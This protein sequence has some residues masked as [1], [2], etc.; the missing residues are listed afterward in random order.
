MDVLTLT[1]LVALHLGVP[2]DPASMVGAQRMLV[3]GAATLVTFERNEVRRMMA[4]APRLR[5]RGRTMVFAVAATGDLQMALLSGSGR[6][7][8]SGAGFADLATATVFLQGC[9]A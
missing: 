5:R 3:T 4:L 9:G 7:L 6:V 8:C 1:M 2:A